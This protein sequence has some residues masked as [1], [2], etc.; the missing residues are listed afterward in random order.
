[1][2]FTEASRIIVLSRNFW[3]GL[4][5]LAFLCSFSLRG[6]DLNRERPLFRPS[7]EMRLVLIDSA[8]QQI[9]ISPILGLYKFLFSLPA[10]R[11]LGLV[12]RDYH[13]FYIGCSL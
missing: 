3:V 7:L 9:Y 1:M 11:Q 10:F 13:L 12:D 2:G 6:Y 5:E 8:S 4:E